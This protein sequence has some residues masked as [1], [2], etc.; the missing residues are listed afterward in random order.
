MTHIERKDQTSVQ[1]NQKR[2]SVFSFQN[3]WN[4]GTFVPKDGYIVLGNPRTG[5]GGPWTP[6]LARYFW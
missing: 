1:A 5:L 4:T 6:A 2:K 3:Q